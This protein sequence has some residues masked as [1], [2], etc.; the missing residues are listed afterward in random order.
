MKILAIFAHPDDEAFGPGGT[1]SRY[2]LSGHTVRL[3]TITRGEAGTLGPAQ[4]LTRSELGRMRADELRCS[5]NALHVSALNIHELPDGKLAGLPVE[6]GLTIVR[7]EINAFQP[8]ALITFHAAGISGHPDHQTVARWCLH[9]VRERTDG[10][11]LFSFGISEEQVRRVGYRKLTPIPDH[12]ITHVIDV[13]GHVEH[14]LQAIRCHQ[15]QSESWERMRKVAGGIESYL[16]F[17]HFSRIWPEPMPRVKSE[18][19]ED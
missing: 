14:K 8:D 11:R 4:H 6:D 19:L 12:E 9:A 7:S 5:A 15:S 16:R 13:S 18:R 1:L 3:V 10:L 2:A 17:E